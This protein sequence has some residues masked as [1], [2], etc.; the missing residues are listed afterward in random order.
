M[1][2]EEETSCYRRA[3]STVHPRARGGRT[4]RSVAAVDMTGSP[5]R[6]G[7]KARKRL[8]PGQVGRLTPAR[9]GKGQA[10]WSGNI[11]TGSLS[12]AGRTQNGGRFPLL[13]RRFTPARGEDGAA[14]RQGGRVAVGSPPRTGRTARQDTPIQRSARFTP[15]R[16]RWQWI[17]PRT[18][19][20]AGS[21]PRGGGSAP[22]SGFLV[23][24]GG[25][26]PRA[27]R[28]EMMRQPRQEPARLTPARGEDGRPRDR[29]DSN[30]ARFTP[31][32][33]KTN[34]SDEPIT[35]G[36][37]F[38]PTHGDDSGISGAW[39]TPPPVHPLAG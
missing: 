20:S 39:G 28:T 7:R 4:G 16:G 15:A 36:T 32:R 6:A 33:G 30:D 27:G 25:S 3:G 31:T 2:G 5:P 23:L 29:S 37:R 24:L 35:Q 12:R 10:G 9:G 1:C 26:P 8:D 11:L 17:G 13:A 22:G 38:T 34:R 14:S 19:A 21:P 18:T